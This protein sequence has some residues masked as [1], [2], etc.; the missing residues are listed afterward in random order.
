MPKIMRPSLCIDYQV[1]SMNV[2]DR[3]WWEAARA[4]GRASFIFREGIIRQ[5]TRPAAVI[6]VVALLTGAGV[7]ASAC[8]FVVCSISIG[9]VVGFTLWQ[10]FQRIF[11]GDQSS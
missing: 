8:G 11:G 4:H 6:A 1:L 3:T 9:S 10:R 5:G 2:T 7:W